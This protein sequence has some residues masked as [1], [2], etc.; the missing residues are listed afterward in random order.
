[1]NRQ[2]KYEAYLSKA[3]NRLWQ[4]ARRTCDWA[5][6]CHSHNQTWNETM[7]VVTSYV[8]APL[9]YSYVDWLMQDAIK[10]GV[11]RLYFLSRDGWHMLAVAQ[12]IKEER[13]SD[14]EL[15]YL[16]CSR[17]ALQ[18][19][20]YH[21]REDY[22]EQICTGG[23]AISL[24]QVLK[25]GGLSAEEVEHTLM[26]HN[27]SDQGQCPLSYQQI[28][29]LKRTLRLD[30]YFCGLVQAHSMEAY[31]ACVGYLRQEGL[32]DSTVSAIVDSG[33]TGGMQEALGHIL[34]AGGKERAVE[35]YYFGLYELPSGMK[36]EMYHA[37]YFSP[38]GHWK[39][40]MQ[41]NNNVL[42]A[43]LSSPEGMT[44]GYD[45]QQNRYVP[46]L[47]EDNQEKGFYQE[48]ERLLCYF[49]SE[50][51]QLVPDAKELDAGREE[52]CRGIEGVLR[53]FMTYPS[54]E[55]A[56]YYGSMEFSDHMR[57]CGGNLLA[58]PVTGDIL[59]ANHILFRYLGR[60]R[61]SYIPTSYWLMGSLARYDSSPMEKWWHRV[62]IL[63]Y[64]L[65]L[66]VRKDMTD[67]KRKRL[68]QTR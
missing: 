22:I 5:A 23:K 56:V 46:V 33:W 15:R 19:P 12:M 11:R 37:F 6:D 64:Y 60:K 25:R 32:F 49:C 53:E 7:R 66:Y 4:A 2:Q 34:S 52:R 16:Y 50:M 9:L 27:L 65:A 54:R 28:Q 10:R 55:E 58:E 30:S 29:G 42:E 36:E 40:K 61:G 51:Q 48:Q 17:Y 59:R 14:L 41:F 45:R 31:D 8:T 35:G 62:W 39:R 20:A 57:G 26:L 13:K 68:E 44:M 67:R 18:L 1:M 38:K 3:S 47:G 24:E 63:A 21:L 43:L